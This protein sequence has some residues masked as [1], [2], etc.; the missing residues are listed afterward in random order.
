VP[1]TR[2]LL[3]MHWLSDVVTSTLMGAA[4][5]EAIYRPGRKPE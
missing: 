2:V 1:T 5:A 4:V 3:G